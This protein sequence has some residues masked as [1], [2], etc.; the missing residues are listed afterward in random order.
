MYDLAVD[1]FADA[2]IDPRTYWLDPYL[3]DVK[4]YNPMPVVK[5]KEALQLIANAGRCIITQG[6]N[7]N[8]YMKSSFAPD[9]TV[10]TEDAAYYSQPEK[11]F[12]SGDKSEY[13]ISAPEYTRVDSQMFF[14]PREQEGVQYLETGY[15]SAAITDCLLY[16]SRCV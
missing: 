1:V 15:I 7:G 11:I 3:K 4:V 12:T 6:R 13:A 5:H 16:T 9:M 14:L 10:Q 2:G 8:I